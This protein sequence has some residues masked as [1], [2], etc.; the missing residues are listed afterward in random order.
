MINKY[1][2]II[3]IISIIILIIC[4]IIGVLFI[5]NKYIQFVVGTILSSLSI[6]VFS[7]MIL[8]YMLDKRKEEEEK[9]EY[10]KK[11]E[12]VIYE[13][14]S[15]IKN[16]NELIA[17]MYK[18]TMSNPIKDDNKILNDLYYN[19]DSLYAQLN[20]LDMNKD[21]YMSSITNNIWDF[22]SLNWKQCLLNK[23][24]EYIDS[25]EKIKKNYFYLLEA[26]I[27]NPMEKII[28]IKNSIN[29]IEQLDKL[30]NIVPNLFDIYVPLNKENLYSTNRTSE[31]IQKGEKF[32]YNLLG[33]RNILIETRELIQY[34]NRY[35]FKSDFRITKEFFNSTNTSPSI[36]SGL[37]D[38]IS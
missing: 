8:I 20:L 23:I 1:R 7:S 32:L 36:G 12:L 33:F 15:S 24:K 6:N 3:L 9:K 22:Q 29:N 14:C 30:L 21:G 26:E 4:C 2:K 19:I 16:F 10:D 38:D 17:N 28:N 35:N 5:N 37:L 25:L 27:I 31:N 11:R 34:I 13:I 18:A